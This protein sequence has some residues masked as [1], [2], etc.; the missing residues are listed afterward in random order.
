MVLIYWNTCTWL[1]ETSE[2]MTDSLSRELFPSES[3]SELFTYQGSPRVRL[4]LTPSPDHLL[5]FTNMKILDDRPIIWLDIDNT[6]YP[7]S[8]KVADAM[9]EKIHGML[10]AFANR[11]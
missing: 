10:I 6:L 9:C 5:L 8:A 3:E 4:H 2:F 11:K 7:A 1:C